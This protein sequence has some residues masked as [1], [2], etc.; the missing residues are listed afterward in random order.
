M[1]RPDS[2]VRAVRR[3]LARGTLDGLASIATAGSRTHPS[4]VDQAS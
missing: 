2:N 1:N 3:H 4:A